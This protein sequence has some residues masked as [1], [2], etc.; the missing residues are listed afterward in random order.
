VAAGLNVVAMRQSSRCRFSKKANT[1]TRWYAAWAHCH[2]LGIIQSEAPP[3][4]AAPLP[5]Y[6]MV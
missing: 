1:S 3:R 5:S 6:T 2:W 4:G